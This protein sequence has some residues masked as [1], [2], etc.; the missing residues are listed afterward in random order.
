MYTYTQL[1]AVQP[2]YNLFGII[3]KINILKIKSNSQKQKVE[4]L[5]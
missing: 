4:E 1:E 2:R 3:L 5:G